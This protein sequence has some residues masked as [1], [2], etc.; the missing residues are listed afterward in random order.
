MRLDTSMS[1]QQVPTLFARMQMFSLIWVL[2]IV[3][4][5]VKFCVLGSVHV[6]DYDGNEERCPVFPLFD[7]F[8]FYRT[9]AS[10]V[11][12]DPVVCDPMA[13]RPAI[14]PGCTP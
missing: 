7:R 5:S 8:G 3:V 6:D 9:M 10:G 14:S 13:C 12:P 4:E 11:H 2:A 1:A